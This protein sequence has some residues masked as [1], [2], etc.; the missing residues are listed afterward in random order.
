MRKLKVENA[1][2]EWVKGGYKIVLPKNVDRPEEV[3]INLKPEMEDKIDLMNLQK[4]LEESKDK[5]VY[6]KVMDVIHRIIIKSYPNI[7]AEGQ[8]FILTKFGDELLLELYFIWGWRNRA[9]YEALLVKQKKT[10]E[11]IKNGNLSGTSTGNPESPIVK[12]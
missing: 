11:D 5:E 2:E 9:A 8:K 6:K 1:V 7:G 3:E 4:E 10:I 12:E